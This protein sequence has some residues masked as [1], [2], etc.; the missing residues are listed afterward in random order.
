MS[1][2]CHCDKEALGRKLQPATCEFAVVGACLL[3][4]RYLFQC[5]AALANGAA[6]KKEWSAAAA[7]A[8]AAAAESNSN[9]GAT[10][11]S[12]R[13]RSI[14]SSRR[15]AP[16]SSRRATTHS[17]RRRAICSSRRIE[18]LQQCLANQFMVCWCSSWACLLPPQ[19]TSQGRVLVHLPSRCPI[20]IPHIATLATCTRVAHKDPTRP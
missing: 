4:A 3:L 11:H 13:R 12:S 5:L 1:L 10:T 17:S 9:F 15:R 18:V 14:C 16:H 6:M 19:Q 20:Q 8:A 7:A 2:P